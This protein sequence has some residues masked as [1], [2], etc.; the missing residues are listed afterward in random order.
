MIAISRILPSFDRKLD[1]AMELKEGDFLELNAKVDGSPLPT[2]TWYKNGE[3]IDTN[4]PRIKIT[5]SP[6]GKCKLRI[7]EATPEDS[8]AYKLVISNSVGESESQCAVAVDSKM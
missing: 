6:D 4:D 5:M 2:A 8:G 1:R 3:P 7:E